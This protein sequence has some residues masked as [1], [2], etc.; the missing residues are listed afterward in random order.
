MPLGVHES[1]IMVSMRFLTCAQKG[2][3]TLIVVFFPVIIGYGLQ[4]TLFIRRE[5]LL[6]DSLLLQKSIV[7]KQESMQKKIQ[8][9]ARLRAS[10]QAWCQD[11]ASWC[12][13]DGQVF[14]DSWLEK[15][16]IHDLECKMIHPG[17]VNQKNGCIFQSFD[18]SYKGLFKNIKTFIHDF[19][20]TNQVVCSTFLT[21]QRH[22]HHRVKGIFSISFLVGVH[23]G[24]GV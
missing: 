6:Q 11:H 1:R 14:A 21:M 18:V 2:I 16:K 17:Q 15:M 22:K 8:E 10:V 12:A 19:Y 4:S 13:S 23:D 24:R 20:D 5:R 9:Y 7:Q 3:I